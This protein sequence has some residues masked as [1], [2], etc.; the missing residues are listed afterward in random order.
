[1]IDVFLRNSLLCLDRFGWL[2]KQLQSILVILA[3]LSLFG[4]LC[5]ILFVLGTIFG[6]LTFIIVGI[7]IIPTLFFIYIIVAAPLMIRSA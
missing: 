4:T 1:M 7:I 2:G 6:G 5:L 3:F